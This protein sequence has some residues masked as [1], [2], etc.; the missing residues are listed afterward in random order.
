MTYGEAKAAGY[1][2]SEI[3]LS[4]RGYYVSR[5]VIIDNQ[6]VLTA[7]GYRR[8][9]LYVEIPSFHSTMYSYRYYLEEPKEV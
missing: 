6:P 7:G 9:E 2:V 5:N 8:G 3:R 1:R 4:R